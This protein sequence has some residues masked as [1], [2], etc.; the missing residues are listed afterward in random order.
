MHGNSIDPTKYKIVYGEIAKKIKFPKNSVYFQKKP[1]ENSSKTSQNAL[2][3]KPEEIKE[4]K[5]EKKEGLQVEIKP[6]VVETVGKKPEIKDKGKEFVEKI[7]NNKKMI[8]NGANL[9]LDLEEI[10][11]ESN[12]NFILTLF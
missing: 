5:N 1:P 9:L 10:D 7:E 2:E 4:N 8:F 3:K 12:F 6:K 11:N